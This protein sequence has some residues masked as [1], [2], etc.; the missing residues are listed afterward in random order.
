MKAIELCEKVKREWQFLTFKVNPKNNKDYSV[1]KDRVLEEDPEEHK[2]KHIL[3]ATT[4]N[5]VIQ[6]RD[7]L[8][9]KNKIKFESL[10]I[11]Q[12]IDLTWKVVK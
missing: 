6:V 1:V 4:A 7:A 8:N 9:D 5:T 12:M 2:G 11:F 10:G 3:D